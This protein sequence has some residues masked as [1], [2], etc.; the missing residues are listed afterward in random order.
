[1]EGLAEDAM[2]REREQLAAAIYEFRD[3][4]CGGPTNMGRTDHSH[5]LNVGLPPAT[6]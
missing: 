6:N 2:S 4:F 3:V 5:S 1:M